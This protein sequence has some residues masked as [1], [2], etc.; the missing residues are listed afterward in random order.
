[1]TT[2]KTSEGL[3]S[4]VGVSGLSLT[5]VN[6]TI[7]AGIF[8]LP[9]VISIKLGAFGIFSYLF[10]TLM[11]AAV[12]L[13]YME[14]GSRFK[15]SGGS[16][17]YVEE[18]F[19]K[20]PAFIVNWLL[21]FG[22][23][24]LA[25]AAVINIIADSLA[26]LFPVFTQ[27]AVRALLFLALLGAIVLINIRGTKG[28]VGFIKILT[29]IKLLPLLAIII[30]GFGFIK[31][32]N[33][34]WEHLPSLKTFSGASLALFF[35]FAGFE[36]ILG[37]SGELKNPKRTVPLGILFG[38]SIVLVIYL[39]LQTVTQGVIGAE[40]IAFEN[41]PLSAVAEK[42]VGPFGAVILLIAASFSSFAL[43]SGDLMAS[44][45]ILFAGANDGLHPMFLGK[46]HPKFSTP[47]MAIIT[48][49]VIIFILAVTGGF[50]QLAILASAAILLV[51]L[52][53]I[54]AT[55]KFRIKKQKSSEKTFKMPGGLTIPVIGIAATLWLLSSLTKWEILSALIFIGL[56][57]LIYFAM[58]QFTKR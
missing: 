4:V 34:H 11:M 40:I 33:L 35:A 1:M 44:P 54:F 36:T 42:I 39:M 32:S 58:K 55:I 6:G 27:P 28:T 24:A 57:M 43:L 25:C 45:R 29:V 20:F 14:T 3:K 56:V 18:A 23:G 16:Y 13:C 22:W 10:C 17:A 37:V 9:A 38:G 26:V 21:F 19:G 7:G 31:S 49:A 8:T 12:M 51:Y 30:F 47:Y 2:E 52:A 15:T 5:I 46:V 50:K 41:A 48:Y 53:V